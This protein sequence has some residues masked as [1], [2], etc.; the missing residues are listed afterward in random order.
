MFRSA[1]P[2]FKRK[3][4]ATNRG[5]GARSNTTGR[6]EQE[7]RAPADD[8]WGDVPP[9]EAKTTLTTERPRRIIT[10]NDSPFVGFDRSINPY[11][12]CEHGCVYCFARPTHAYLGLSP[13]VDFESRLFAKPEAAALLR[14]ELSAAKYQCRP[15]AIGTNTDPYQPAERRLGIMRD[16]LRVLDAFSHPV[17]ILTKSDL[18]LRDLDLLVPMARRGIARAMISITTE[19]AALARAMEP[20]APTPDKRF[21]AVTGLA[22]AGIPT[23]TVHGPMI[24][25][26]TD[27]ELEALMARAR[28]AGAS[29]A[30]YTLLRLPLE[31]AP[32]MEEWLHDHAPHHAQKVLGKMR[33]LNGGKLY[34]VNWSRGEGPRAI[35]AVLLKQRYEAALRR[36]QFGEMPP[37][38]TDLFAVPKAPSAQGELFG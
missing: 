36:L 1:A 16:I 21:A 7:T 34:D 18:I 27:H 25:G 37:L 5:R 12:G 20:R 29:Y 28:E 14:R 6:Y 35:E 17:S 9:A 33:A 13:G 31:V 3:L 24:P 2:S 10:Y 30:A 23:G 32:L 4:Q 22:A 38:R 8:G 26:L 11:R 19:D 15:I